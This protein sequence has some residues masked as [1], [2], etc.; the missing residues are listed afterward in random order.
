[1]IGCYVTGIFP[2]P[3]R[4]I[5]ITRA[6][7]REIAD[8]REL[9]EAFED[10]TLKVISA[11]LSADFN[12]ITDGMLKWQDL[13]RPI[14]ENLSGVKIGSLAKWFNNDT[15]YRKPVIMDDLGWKR[16]IVEKY[17]HQAST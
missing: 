3:K 15:F 10:T 7:D 16:S 6:Y 2:R 4:L 8:E 1:M 17:I 12:C 14:A 13:I 5:E 9:E 11:Q